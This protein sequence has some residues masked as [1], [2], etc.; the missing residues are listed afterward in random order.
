LAVFCVAECKQTLAEIV[1]G[2]S[3]VSVVDLFQ[4]S[5]NML[6]LSIGSITKVVWR[7]LLAVFLT[8]S[9]LIG[10]V[11]N[12]QTAARCSPSARE[13]GRATVAAAGVF[14]GRLEGFGG[15]P[16]LLLHDGRLNATFSFRQKHK[17][18]FR[19]VS[20]GAPVVVSLAVPADSRTRTTNAIAGCSVS[21]LLVLRRNYVVFVGQSDRVESSEDRSG[22]IFFQSTAFPVT[23]T[24]DAVKQIEAYHCRRCGQWSSACCDTA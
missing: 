22:L 5:A 19:R 21:D 3:C 2:V 16:S 15:P 14:E 17:G 18:K 23:A 11:S 20:S 7:T 24:K 13:L 6:R 12:Q 8:V 4:F 9:L 10:G 1:L